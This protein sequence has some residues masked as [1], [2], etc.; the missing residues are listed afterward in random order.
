[1][2]DRFLYSGGTDSLENFT[3]E[4]SASAPVVYKNPPPTGPE[5]LYTTGAG[6]G[7]KCP[8]RFSLQQWWCGMKSWRRFWEGVL[9]RPQKWEDSQVGFR[10]GNASGRRIVLLPG[11]FWARMVLPK[12]PFWAHLFCQGVRC[13]HLESTSSACGWPIW[14]KGQSAKERL[15]L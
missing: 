2:K 5:I 13:V 1:M 3:A 9:V 8:W 10:G 4:F 6:E 7:G 14:L 12:W 15:R 11:A